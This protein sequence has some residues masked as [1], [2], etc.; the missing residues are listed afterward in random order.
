LA[1]ENVVNH[2]FVDLE[3][4]N[5]PQTREF[6]A[7]AY[8]SYIGTHCDHMTLREPDRTRFYEGVRDAIRKAG[9]RITLYD[10]I[11]LYLARKP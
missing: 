6:T 2:G 11:A 3:R 7:D 10:T 5:Y 8:V 1:Y 9:D 4:R